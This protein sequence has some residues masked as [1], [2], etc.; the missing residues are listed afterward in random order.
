MRGGRPREI[1]RCR[2]DPTERPLGTPTCP[3]LETPGSRPPRISDILPPCLYC[4]SPSSVLI[5]SHGLG[6]LHQ[7]FLPPRLHT[8]C[9]I[10]P[11]Y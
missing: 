6:K 11:F 10:E 8:C 2:L 4:S 3:R 7:T 5:Y 1:G 9:Y